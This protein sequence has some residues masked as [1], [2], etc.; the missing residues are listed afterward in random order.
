MR[1]LRIIWKTIKWTIIILVVLIVAAI[2]AAFFVDWNNFKP[3]I[4]RLVH[5]QT[6]REFAINGDISLRPS[7]SPFFRVA[8]VTF[9]NAQWSQTKEMA[10]FKSL[11][12]SISVPA[13]LRGEL[14]VSQ[15]RLIGPK[16]LLEQKT[17]DQANWIFETDRPP[18]QPRP[19]KAAADD[20]TDI[21]EKL[22]RVRI[23]EFVLQDLD[24]TYIDHVNN[25]TQQVFINRLTLNQ[26]PN[27][28]IR[29]ALQMK[30][31]DMPITLNATVKS[32]ESLTQFI[33]SSFSFQTTGIRANG[34]LTINMDA[35]VP[36]I[37]GSVS[38]PLL[39]LTAFAADDKA[40]AS[41]PQQAKPAGAK[42][43]PADPLPLDGLKAANVN[44]SLDI[45]KIIVAE[46]IAPIERL[47]STLML[48]NGTLNMP[49]SGSL[50]GGTFKGSITVTQRGFTFKAD[51]DLPQTRKLFINESPLDSGAFA[52]RFDLTGQGNSV[53]AWMGSLNGKVLVT[54]N[55]F[56]VSNNVLG[57][58]PG[59]LS[60]FFVK[61][62]MGN[63][64]LAEISC[65]VVNLDIRNGNI[66][67]TRRVGVET[68]ILNFATL[69]SINLKNE[70]L[71]ISFAPMTARGTNAVTDI[72]TRFSRVT[73]TFA[74]PRTTFNAQGLATTAV[75]SAISVF[76]TA[77]VTGTDLRSVLTTFQDSDASPCRTALNNG[78]VTAGAQPQR[79]PAAV[80]PPQNVIDAVETGKAIRDDVRGVIR[81]IGR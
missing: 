63:S 47:D 28:D 43:F 62:L 57:A 30:H 66:D 58:K 2:T 53:A 22:K 78:V 64:R 56:V 32:L 65:A 71:D 5:D 67:M 45:G 37:T 49:L 42:V 72:A 10:S 33:I 81:A 15:F 25:T 54:A 48:N 31:Q 40:A 38:I 75:Q 80:Q 9:G 34:N 35:Q 12:V 51:A 23:A 74:D 1:A 60:D 11:E 14:V 7:L 50:A 44:L 52:A 8:D 6:G 55:E 16:I 61:A 13:L 76:A 18:A 3:Q 26:L 73:G 20:Q 36:R 46:N 24:L 39:D 41:Q 79:A 27:R 17:A 21:I 4:S 70:T 77:R 59:T 68:P 29:I 19:A 69:G